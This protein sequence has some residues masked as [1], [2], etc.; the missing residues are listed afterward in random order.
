MNVVQTKI[1]EWAIDLP[2]WEQFALQ[3]VIDGKSLGG[4]DY[5]LLL[6]YMLEDIGLSKSKVDRP[7]LR[8]DEE[9]ITVSPNIKVQLTAISDLRNINALASN[10]RLEFGPQLT[11]IFGKNGSGKSGYARVLGSAAF[12]RGDKTIL[13]NVLEP[14]DEEIEQTAIITIKEDG[15]E[16]ELLYKVGENCPQLAGYYVF[17]STAVF[18]H[19]SKPNEIVFSPAGLAWLP[20]LAEITD[21]VRILLDK[22]IAERAKKQDFRIYFSGQS[23]VTELI[24]QLSYDTDTAVLE[25]LATLSPSEGARRKQ[26]PIQVA[27][28]RLRNSEEIVKDLRQTQTDLDK[29]LK[30]LENV[31]EA[32]SDQVVDEFRKAMVEQQKWEKRAKELS[33]ERFV[34]VDINQTSLDTWINF[35]RAAREL[36]RTIEIEGR[37]YPQIGEQCLLC[38]QPLTSEAVGFIQQLWNFLDEEIQEALERS[39]KRL[40]KLRQEIRN[41]NLS[42]FNPQAVWYRY[43]SKHNPQTVKDIEHFL[44]RCGQRK[45]ILLDSQRPSELEDAHLIPL[46]ENPSNQVEHVLQTLKTEIEKVEEE[47]ASDEI[48]RLEA[49]KNLLDHRFILSEKKGEIIAYVENLKWAETAKK[50]RGSTRH[51]TQKYNE[52]FKELVTNQYIA[53]FE[54]TLKK[55]GRPLNVTIKTRGKKGTTIRTVVVTADDSIS[56]RVPPDKVLSEGEKRA[57]ALADFLTEVTID[58]SSRG[59]ILD[60]P[61]TSLDLSWRKEIA[62]ILVEEASSQQVIVFTHDLPFLY[63]LKSFAEKASVQTRTH[64]IQRRDDR[65]GYVFLDNSPALERE[66]RKATYAEQ[67]YSEAKSAQPKEQERLLREGFGALRTSYEAFIIFELFNEV[68]MRFDERISVGRL[69]Q[70]IWDPTIVQEVIDAT[71]RLSRYIEGHLHTDGIT[72]ISPKLLRQEIDDFYELKKRYKELKRHAKK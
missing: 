23:E 38:H 49:E 34:S 9:I 20:K 37:S 1:F 19:M 69:K 62:E 60:D 12:T 7:I 57:V 63:F 22:E 46:P 45:T 6:N 64:W 15:V 24:E 42:F 18:V 29:L 41:L 30:H 21:H 54:K 61:V 4:N 53:I 17:D 55:L 11:A 5:E 48:A 32:L 28:F 66:Y 10:Q 47:D 13:P 33:S 44:E 26:L 56:K 58:Q 36:A 65:P 70:I 14:V 8:F 31:E 50:K 35:I 52:L 68:V 16:K 40:K 3:Q 71:E 51:I 2:Y 27:E 72:D 39:N 67:A 25:Q 59:I 43:L